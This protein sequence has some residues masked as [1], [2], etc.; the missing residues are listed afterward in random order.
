MNPVDLA[1]LKLSD[2]DLVDIRCL[3]DAEERDRKMQRLTAVAYD[4]PSGSV[5]GYYPELNT[6]VPLKHFDRT[7]G[8]PSYKGVPVAVARAGEHK[9]G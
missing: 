8:T 1:A 4:I 6:L 5:A 3:V 2:G 7:S 9:G